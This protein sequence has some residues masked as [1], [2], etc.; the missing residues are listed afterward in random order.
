MPLDWADRRTTRIWDLVAGHAA[1]RGAPAS[2]TDACAAAVAAT[3]VSGAGLT[4]DAAGP[5][6][7]HVICA[8]D[9]LSERIEEL[10]LTAGEG[11]CMD[12]S[13]SGGPVF[14]PDLAA[15]AAG[16][17]WPGFV[18]PARRAGVAAI[19]AFPLRAGAIPV[20]VL[21]LYR[22]RP[23]ALSTAQLGD[24]LLFADT[25]T[26][27]ML[28]GQGQGQ[29]QAA[30]RWWPSAD[31]AGQPAGLAVHRAEIDQATGM[32]TEQL[33]IGIEDAF[34]RLRAY[35]HVHDLRLADVA[36]DI[37]A[38]R[39]RLVPDPLPPGGDARHGAS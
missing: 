26:V 22:D 8:T 25:V 20:G 19:F 18:P 7:G 34:V 29:G 10:Q 38:R 35:A 21:D 11:P 33:D 4:A 6:A 13:A 23:G 15:R 24:A 37:V 27:L 39:L 3:A 31:P 32:L 9:D 17:R 1:A 16:R 28:G 36:R 2:V 5:R 12:A 30:L 14:I